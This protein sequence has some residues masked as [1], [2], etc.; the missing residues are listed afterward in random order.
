MATTSDFGIDAG[1][2]GMNQPKLKNRWRV[3]FAG[4]GSNGNAR[5]LSMQM[6]TAA[7]P[8]LDFDEVVVNRYNSTAYLPGKHKWAELSIS[9]EDDIK[10]LAAQFIRKQLARQQ[11][12]IGGT[13]NGLQAAAAEGSLFKFGMHIDMLDGGKVV[14]E[15]WSV[16]GVWIKSVNWTELDYGASDQVKIDMTLRFDHA[17]QSFAFGAKYNG[18]GSALGGL[19]NAASI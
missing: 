16:S 10:S 19:I 12:L 1:M 13:N 3:T 8:S 9:C 17:S 7:R 4:V 14:L 6:V 15:R 2:I 11:E 18:V 5:D